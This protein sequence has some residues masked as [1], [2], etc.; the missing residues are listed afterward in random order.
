LVDALRSCFAATPKFAEFALPLL[1][2]KLCSTL[3]S[4]KI[5]S[6]ETLAA[7]APVYGVH[8]LEEYLGSLWASIRREVCYISKIVNAY[9]SSLHHC[10]RCLLRLTNKLKMLLYM[11]LLH[12]VQLFQSR[13]GKSS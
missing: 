6:F 5:D 4:A 12:C 13:F 10:S 3:S 7:C 9:Q 11:P 1:L 2:E 8:A